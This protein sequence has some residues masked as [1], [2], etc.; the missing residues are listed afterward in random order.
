MTREVVDRLRAEASREDYASM[1]RLA[2]ALYETGLG[3]RE[4]LRDCYGV[5]FPEEVF[6][7]VDGGLW[8]LDL[9]A[10]FTNQ[11]WQ[12]ALPP[13]RGGPAAVP[14]SMAATEQ[15]LLAEDPDLIPLVRVPAAAFG[16]EDRIVCYRLGELRAGRSTVFRLFETSDA[17]EAL[18]CGE[19]LLE[20]L[21]DEHANAVRRLE[22]QQRKPSNW[23]AGSVDDEEVEQAYE[24]L[25]R[26]RDL[27]REAAGRQGD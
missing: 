24:S 12:L 22:E 17:D 11:P 4:V 3:P 2:R 25:E 14:N 1:T 8:R 21:H 19:S 16:K 6:V 26:V 10:R 18:C 15:R 7:L 13:D 27:Q 5:A 20:I 23:G 9:R